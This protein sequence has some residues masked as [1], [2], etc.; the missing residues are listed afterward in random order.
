MGKKN[1]FKKLLYNCIST[2]LFSISYLLY[3]FNSIFK[4]YL[5]INF[6]AQWTSNIKFKFVKNLKYEQ[7]SKM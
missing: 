2:Y 7:H 3:F 4:L 1:V 5:N 6:E